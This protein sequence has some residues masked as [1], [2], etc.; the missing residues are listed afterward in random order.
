MSTA[1][2]TATKKIAAKTVVKT[3]VKAAVKPVIKTAV[4]AP[5]KP[6][7]APAKKAVA[8][9]AKAPAKTA[10]VK[11]TP[12][13]KA[14]ASK[15]AAKKAPAKKVALKASAKPT[16]AHTKDESLAPKKSVLRVRG[17]ISQTDKLKAIVVKALEDIK[18]RDMVI[19]D[20]RERTSEMDLLVIA[21]G[22]S[23]RH[24][25]AMANAVVQ[26]AKAAKLPPIGVEGERESEWVLVDLADIVVHLMLPR[27]REFYALE[28]LWGGVTPALPLDP[29][30]D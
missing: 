18:A 22:T 23:N 27:A 19:L 30:A 24:V 13:K 2:K 10:A 8:K 21:S 28:R 26:A 17:P 16:K 29:F 1:K 11:K 5:A 7:A 9:T 6:A 20:V 12:A 14:A 25:S 3:A 15:S 4:K